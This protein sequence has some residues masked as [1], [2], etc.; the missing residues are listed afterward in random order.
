V[1]RCRFHNLNYDSALPRESNPPIP[2]LALEPSCG[3]RYVNAFP[4]GDAMFR[5]SGHDRTQYSRGLEI[6]RIDPVAAL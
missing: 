5:R 3:F 6:Q 2:H 1:P 4:Y